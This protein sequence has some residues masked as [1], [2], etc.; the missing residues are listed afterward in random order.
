MREGVALT[1]DSEGIVE[2]SNKINDETKDS[3]KIVAC[4]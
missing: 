4:I 3:F 2:N 1:H